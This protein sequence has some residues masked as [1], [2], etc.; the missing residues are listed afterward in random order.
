MN[1]SKSSY[2]I[3]GYRYDYY[4]EKDQVGLGPGGG[5]HR[6]DWE[7]VVVFS[8]ENSDEII[9]VAPSAHSGYATGNGVIL[10]QGTHPLIVYHKDGPSTHCFRIANGDDQSNPENFSGSFYRSP[11]VGWDNWPNTGLRDQLSVEHWGGATPKVADGRFE[12]ALQKAAGDN[13]P[14]FDPYA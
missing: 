14:G 12:G 8:R 7:N 11:L 4:F 13:V 6:H 10:D 2:L 3:H 1:F 5:G 9:W